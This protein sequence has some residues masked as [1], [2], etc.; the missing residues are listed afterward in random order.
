[1]NSNIKMSTLVTLAVAGMIFGGCGEDAFQKAEVNGCP[2]Y[3]NGCPIDPTDPAC[4]GQDW[5]DECDASGG[6][7]VYI[8]NNNTIDGPKCEIDPTTGCPIDMASELCT[9]YYPIN[10]VIPD[11]M[12]ITTLDPVHYLTAICKVNSKNWPEVKGI[13]DNDK[14]GD[15]DPDADGENWI[16]VPLNYIMTGVDKGTIGAYISTKVIPATLSQTGENGVKLSLA[17]EKQK[18]Y[19]TGTLIGKILV[20]DGKSSQDFEAMCEDIK[21]KYEGYELAKFPYP[22]KPGTVKDQAQTSNFTIQVSAYVTNKNGD[23]DEIF[24]PVPDGRGKLWLNFDLGAPYADRTNNAFNPDA[25]P[26]S[27]EDSYAYGSLWQWGRKADGHQLVVT[28]A[29]NARNPVNS[30]TTNVKDDEPND[31]QFITSSSDWRVNSDDT[32]WRGVT[33]PNRVCPAGYRIPTFLEWEEAGEGVTQGG[34]VWLPPQFLNLQLGGK[35][36]ATDGYIDGVRTEAY[37]WS[38]T[39]TTNNEMYVYHFQPDSTVSGGA[40]AEKKQSIKAQGNPVRCRKDYPVY[41]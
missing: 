15:N 13:I 39:P 25:T 16:T 28:T 36:S 19:P 18:A 37:F 8:E 32:L 27:R 33:A 38:S 30:A 31:T 9:D 34:S 26:T 29:P 41:Q 11:G 22:I 14:N 2:V 24:I 12:E 3:A 23:D 21:D 17:W 35:R 4:V 10:C 5:P 7:T 40:K 1:M 20:D 6:D